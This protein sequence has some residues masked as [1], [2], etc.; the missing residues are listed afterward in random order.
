MILAQG[1]RGPGDEPLQPEP[2]VSRQAQHKS[3]G[4]RGLLIAVPLNYVPRQ[5]FDGLGTHVEIFT[6][7]HPALL[8]DV[9]RIRCLIF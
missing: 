8:R 6:K 9:L 4:T 5:K 1:A 2:R 7:A 3:I